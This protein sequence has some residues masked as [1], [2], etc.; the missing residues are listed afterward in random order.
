MVVKCPECG[1][2]VSSTLSNCPHCGFAMVRGSAL[3][4]DSLYDLALKAEQEGRIEDAINY[5]DKILEIDPMHYQTWLFKGNMISWQ[6][7]DMV[8]KD[9]RNAACEAWEN[10]LKYAPS[11]N[12]VKDVAR[13]ISEDLKLSFEGAQKHCFSILETG[14]YSTED[15]A[16]TLLCLRNYIE[17]H[18]DASKRM[19]EQYR[20]LT[21]EKLSPFSKGISEK[22]DISLWSRMV[23]RLTDVAKADALKANGLSQMPQSYAAA[24]LFLCGLEKS[25]DILFAPEH[26]EQAYR[27]LSG[28]VDSF[29]TR[30][31][32]VGFNGH[33]SPA[34]FRTC[35]HS[36]NIMCR[37][38][39]MGIKRASRFLVW[40][41][42]IYPA[43]KFTSRT[44]NARSSL[45][46]MP[47]ARNVLMMT[48]AL[49]SQKSGFLG[50]WSRMFSS[51]SEYI[52]LIDSC[53]TT[54]VNWIL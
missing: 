44:R 54:W 12:A 53:S 11:D 37:V 51:S 1:G 38:V 24:G 33:A 30:L 26:R 7:A 32:T 4:S 23:F 46:R 2:L 14:H 50:R 22:C 5:I 47:V 52:S 35:S 39:G 27:T 42:V 21:G 43:F 19:D 13:I 45:A 40:F 8:S 3:S 6:V 9:A 17:F 16:V 28:S 20:I 49:K 48:Q 15:F 10:A 41:R 29:Q 25:I 18:N 31:G 36:S 34:A